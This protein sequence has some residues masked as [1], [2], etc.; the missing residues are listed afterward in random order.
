MQDV[1]GKPRG[2]KGGRKPGS[3][4]KAPRKPR[5]MTA[6]KELTERLL[7]RVSASLLQ[8]IQIQASL[9][10]DTI[11]DFLRMVLDKHIE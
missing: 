9:Q 11:P 8:R 10:G 4:D 5:K 1:K 2:R 7:I 6:S 3:K